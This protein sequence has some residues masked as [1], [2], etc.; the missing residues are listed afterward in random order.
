MVTADQPGWKI[1]PFRRGITE[2]IIKGPVGI[3]NALILEIDHA[4]AQRIEDANQLC[5]LRRELIGTLGNALFQDLRMLDWSPV[6]FD[7]WF[8]TPESQS[9]SRQ[10]SRQ[11]VN[12]LTSIGGGGATS[13]LT[14]PLMRMFNNFSYSRLGMGC[15]LENYVCT[16]RGLNDEPDSVLIMEGSGVPNLSI[17]VFNRRMDWPQLVSNLSA[18]T[19]GESI[20]IGDP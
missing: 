19:S 6:S 20:R 17:R 1:F 11:A 16:I 4:F 14:G 18:T 10:I 5:T 7:A 9:R 13:A 2:E 12:H 3:D 15:K 8:G